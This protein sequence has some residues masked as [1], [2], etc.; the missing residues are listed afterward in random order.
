MLPHDVAGRLREHEVQQQVCFTTV[1]FHYCIF[2]RSV[3]S[4]AEFK[5]VKDLFKASCHNGTT[6]TLPSY[7]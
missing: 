2:V 4:L 6:M 3:P 5:D 1:M 7:Q